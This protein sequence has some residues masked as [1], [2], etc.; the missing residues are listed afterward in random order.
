MQPKARDESDRP[1]QHQGRDVRRK[2]HKAQIPNVASENE[3][4]NEVIQNPV[5]DEIKSAHE[6]VTE[7]QETEIALERRI[8]EVDKL[9]DFFLQ[10]LFQSCR[11]GLVI[12]LQI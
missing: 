2:G 11:H 1:F 7:E 8:E 9:P 3:M 6:S 4:I 5:D 10:I 12:R